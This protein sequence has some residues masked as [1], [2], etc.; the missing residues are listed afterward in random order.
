MPGPLDRPTAM[1]LM[2]EADV[3]AASG[4]FQDAA[5]AYQRLVGSADPDIHTAALLGLADARYRL[6]DEAGAQ[7]TW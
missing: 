6:D 1:N 4:E 5:R 3:L 2:R 7:V